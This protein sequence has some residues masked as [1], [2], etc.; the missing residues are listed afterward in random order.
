MFTIAPLIVMGACDS[1]SMVVLA[2]IPTLVVAV[3]SMDVLAVMLISASDLMS[4]PWLAC[5][6]IFPV[7]SISMLLSELWIVILL[8]PVLSMTSIFSL[9]FVS[10]RRIKWPLREWITRIL[11]CPS[12]LVVGGASL[13][14]HR[15]PIT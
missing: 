9:P 8:P 6:V 4:M 10:S 11:F 12:L 13:P 15:A 1:I 3:I 2:V 5:S 7:H 14:F